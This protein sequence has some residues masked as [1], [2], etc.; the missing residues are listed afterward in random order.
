MPT[1]TSSTVAGEILH[2]PSR[3]V[4]ETEL[5]R[6]RGDFREIAVPKNA[7]VTP[8]AHDWLRQHGVRLVRDVE[9]G[10]KAK[11]NWICAQERPFSVVASVVE[12]LRKEGISL[13]AWP[14]RGSDS[15]IQ[16]ARKLAEEVSH[17]SGAI[18]FCHDPAL[19]CCVANRQPRIRA[20]SVTNVAL[21]RRALDTMAANWL[22]IEWPGPTYFEI[23]Q[24]LALVS[25]TPVRDCPIE[26]AACGL[27]GSCT[28]AS[29]K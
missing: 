29:P 1:L 21:A 13:H 11:A 20:A 16:W 15:V 17:G 19:V 23:K 10:S 25:R 26:L 7:V 18:V 28:C 12:A 5:A 2:W 22:A 9:K 6:V 3:V 8:S 24:L 14:E 4:S 27:A